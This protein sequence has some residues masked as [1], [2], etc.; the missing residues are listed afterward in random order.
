V[1]N[2]RMLIEHGAMVAL[3]NDSGAIPKTPAMMNVEAQLLELFTGG[4]G[5]LLKTADIVRTATLDAARTIGV[6]GQFGS[7]ETGKAADLA[8]YS[9]NPLT[10]ITVIGSQ[11]D[12]LFMD[13]MPVVDRIDME[14]RG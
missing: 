6:E 5:Q 4:E 2:L 7:I 3:G 10:D 13:G 1:D 14:V 8:V 12:A 9:N 11:V